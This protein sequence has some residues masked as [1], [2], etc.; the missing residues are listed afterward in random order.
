MKLY[1]KKDKEKEI[2]TEQLFKA[3]LRQAFDIKEND[4]A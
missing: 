4:E 3:L 2:L 1:N